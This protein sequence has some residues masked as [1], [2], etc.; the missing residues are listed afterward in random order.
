MAFVR[1]TVVENCFGSFV[2]NY[3]PDDDMWNDINDSWTEDLQG[4]LA[5]MPGDLGLD[6]DMVELMQAVRLSMV[7]DATAG[8]VVNCSTN[9]DS[10]EM[11][12]DLLKDRDTCEGDTE[13]VDDVQKYVM[14]H[15]PKFEDTVQLSIVRKRKRDSDE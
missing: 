3:L 2:P 10:R 11:Y 15:G 5:D 13:L 6:C 9:I 12:D 4:F 14:A 7:I 1:A 8:I